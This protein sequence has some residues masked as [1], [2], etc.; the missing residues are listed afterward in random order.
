MEVD[1]I[2]NTELSIYLKYI[3]TYGGRMV[4][5]RRLDDVI[6]HTQLCVRCGCRPHNNTVILMPI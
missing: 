6:Q 4:L 3:T 2:D 1:N 5:G